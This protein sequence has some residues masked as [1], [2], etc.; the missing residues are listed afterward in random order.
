MTNKLSHM[1]E[2]SDHITEKQYRTSRA[3][4]ILD[5]CASTQIFTVTSG[6]FLSGLAY[7]VG[8]GTALTGI[9]AALPTLMNTI[10]IF[11]SVVYE[12]RAGSKRITVEFALI[13]RLCLL[14]MLFVPTLMLGA[15]ISVA[16]IAVLYSCAHFCGAFINTGANNWLISLVQKERLGRY[17]GLKDSLTLVASTG[18]SLILS[19]IL[20]AYRFADQE[21]LGFRMIGILCIGICAVDI[22]CLTLI[23]EPENVKHVE[24]LNIRKAI[25]MPLT[26]QNYRNILIFFLLWSVASNFA[27]P[28]FSIYMLENLGLSY[29]YITVMNMVASVARIAAANLWGKAA[30]S[31]SWRLVT[32]GSIFMLGV[33]YIGWGLLTKENCIYWLPVVQAVSGA[34]WGGINIA[35]FRMQFAFAP[36]EHRVSY[37]SFCSTM[38][39]FVGFF[40]SMLGSTFV[41]LAKDIRI[42]NIP[43]DNIQ[44][45]FILSA[46]GIITSALYSRKIKEK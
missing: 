3:L 9:I 7:L 28:F 22:T 36:L 26:E 13:Q 41:A 25:Q 20:D 12:N 27:S 43:V 24:P 23:R 35:T 17:L 44:M 32:L 6:A 39:G 14:M 31:C 38:V 18:G 11:S 30:D 5:G 2:C 15:K 40:S 16:V 19:K 10:Q 8:A 37:V 29:F 1:F 45:V 42:L 34:A 21:I 4:F 33:A 46:F